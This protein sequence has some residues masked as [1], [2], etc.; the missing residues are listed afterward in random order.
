MGK[1]SQS[2][3]MAKTNSR[4]DSAPVL[5]VTA[6]LHT[7]VASEMVALLDP[8][9]QAQLV[10]TVARVASVAFSSCRCRVDAATAD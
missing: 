5:V 4:G 2:L 9:L 7:A 8:P 6:H 1:H 10:A 3:Q